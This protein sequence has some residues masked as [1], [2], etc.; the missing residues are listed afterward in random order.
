VDTCPVDALIKRNDG[1]VILDQDLCTG[2]QACIDECPFNIIVFNE[3]NNKAE[4]CNFCSHRID[5]G[6]KPFCLVCCEGQAISFGDLN[7]PNSRVTKLI[8]LRKAFQ[9][10]S[11]SRTDPSVYYCP[12]KPKKHL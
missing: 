7:D 10:K 2:C 8:S 12:T 4:K 3:D 1:L 9:L 11:E 5:Q 6:L